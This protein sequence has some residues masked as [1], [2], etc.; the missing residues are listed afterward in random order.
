MSLPQQQTHAL[1]G[2]I[3]I[4]QSANGL[5]AFQLPNGKRLRLVPQGDVP[6]HVKKYV[7][8][9]S[10]AV[11]NLAHNLI[12]PG[13]QLLVHPNGTI[14]MAPPPK[15]KPPCEGPPEVIHLSDSD[16]EENEITNPVNETT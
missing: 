1:S 15:P 11:I 9:N 16:D 7:Q 4:E 13:S 2:D 3:K 14:E 5:P 10:K 6:E 8:E 12:A